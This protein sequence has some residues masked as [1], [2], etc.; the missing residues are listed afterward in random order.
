MATLTGTINRHK[1]IRPRM[2]LWTG[3]VATLAILTALL[4]VAIKNNPFPAQDLSVL[5]WVSSWEFPGLSAFF[6][7]ISFLT[8]NA[9]GIALGLAGVI[10]FW[11]KG[12]KREAFAFAV[13]G[14]ILGVV[15][16][17]GDYILGEWVGRIRPDA[18]ISSHVSFPSG[19]VFG[20]TVLFGFWI[21]L[22]FHYRLK[23]RLLVPLVG[24]LAFFILATGPA[25]I[26]EQAHWPSDVAAGYLLGALWLL[27]L[28]PLFLKLQRLPS[29][30][31]AKNTAEVAALVVDGVRIEGSIASTIVLD[32]QRG[33]ATKIYQ[34]PALVRFLYWAAFQAKFPYENN[35][36]AL[37]AGA[38][39]RK[40]ASL[41]TLHRFGKDL[42]APVIEIGQLNGKA[43]FVTEFIPGE[44]VENDS[45]V[46]TFLG[47]VTETFA[48]AGLPV[49]Q[50]NPRNPHA[51]TNL[52]RTPEG[53]MKIIDLES[54]VVTPFPARGQF[55]STLRRGGFP[56]F[57]DIDF[58]RLRSYVA[59]NEAAL[60]GSLG[61]RGMA[62]LKDA[63]DRGEQTMHAWKSSELRIVGRTIKWAYRLL[64]WKALYRKTEHAMEGADRVAQT[65]LE[66]GIERWEEDGR[67]RPSEA[68]AMRSHLASQ[69]ASDALHHLG[70]HL[71]LSVAIV[72]PIP[73]LRSLARFG[74]TV[75]FWSASQWRLIRH[76]A[77]GET[78]RT[79][80][81]HSPLVMVLALVPALGG[82]AYLTARPLRRKLL[83]RLMLDQA[84]SKLPLK[85]YARMRLERVLA[86]AP[87]ETNAQPSP[88]PAAAHQHDEMPV[89]APVLAYHH[90]QAPAIAQPVMA[91]TSAYDVTHTHCHGQGGGHMDEHRHSSSHPLPSLAN[92]CKQ[93]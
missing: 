59:A 7:A 30:F 53:D 62:E 60:Q 14:G 49:W 80:N 27:L 33:T 65:F 36:A 23:M 63:M 28:I 68:T 90:D 18:A 86:P 83:I 22:A 5:N 31:S 88:A 48:E 51:H 67:V 45:S 47:Q 74:W 26:H 34:P 41:L 39:R 38:H 11:L 43:T 17:F 37:E 78:P 32:P 52:I 58:D 44:K 50:M 84:A 42:V 75:A 56:I 87:V 6:G 91:F 20:S 1:T 81:I 93:V 3:S 2:V 66:K 73:G 89:P 24:F 69:E 12:L 61:V 72:V 9:P 70:A 15:A 19:H 46:K 57:D 8:N 54:A 85:L 77:T 92:Q 35:N 13:I 55:R 4:T 79:A 64:N 71:V 21:F 40:I 29:I 25:R 16:L 10:F 76:R 82:F